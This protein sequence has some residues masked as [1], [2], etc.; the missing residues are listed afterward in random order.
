[1][2]LALFLIVGA[3][4]AT[5]RRLDTAVPAWQMSLKAKG[6]GARGAAQGGGSRL[7]DCWHVGRSTTATQ[8][9][10]NLGAS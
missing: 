10:E 9:T 6:S 3:S 4:G 5:P 7:K 8:C 1:M 2:H